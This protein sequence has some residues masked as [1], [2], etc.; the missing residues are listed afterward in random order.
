MSDR[1]SRPFE[2]ADLNRVAEAI[3]EAL[4]SAARERLGGA[5]LKQKNLCV[6][7]AR[8]SA[9]Y[10]T[11]REELLSAGEGPVVGS[12][13]D[14]AARALFFTVAD[15]AKVKIPLAEL[16]A[17]GALAE[18]TPLKVLDIGA[19]CGAM[20][21]GLIDALPGVPLD[22]VALDRD[23]NALAIFA[24]AHRRLAAENVAVE[25]RCGNVSAGVDDRV[26]DLA[27]L[28]S[29]LNELDEQAATELVRQVL[30]RLSP[31]GAIV[32]IEPALR[33]CSRR[34]H[35]LRDVL[36]AGGDVHAF[37]PCTRSIAPCPALELERDW[38]HEDR[39]FAPP[40]RLA[41]LTQVTGMRRHR[42]K[43]SYLVL[44]REPG[45][46]G[47]GSSLERVVSSLRKTKGKSELHVCGEN[48]WQKLRLQKRDRTD[49]NRIF[50]RARRGDLIAMDE[51]NVELVDPTLIDD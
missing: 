1:V 15:A 24:A 26:V 45:N 22:I 29:V 47:R 34:L 8:R 50:E 10:T 5:V 13:S 17:A 49:E 32:I 23:Q 6:A 21:L 25:T 46:V 16:A 7:I 28:G 19:G 42:L 35:R 31:K 44:R 40:P 30:A 36:I 3:E 14:L 20:S 41:S 4:W 12:A 51:N 27:L 38:C 37:A 2:V 9:L 33:D 39:S 18:S 11:D 43:F 48:G